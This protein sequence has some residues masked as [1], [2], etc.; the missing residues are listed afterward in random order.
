LK[1][2]RRGTD[3]LMAGRMGNFSLY[4]PS[5]AASTGGYANLF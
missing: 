5:A 2:V 3:A 1:T 4:L